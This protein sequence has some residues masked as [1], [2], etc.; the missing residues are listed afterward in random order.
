MHRE[1]P[2]T[3]ELDDIRLIVDGKKTMFRRIMDKQPD[4]HWLRPC[5]DKDTGEVSAYCDGPTG[6]ICPYGTVGSRLWVREEWRPLVEMAGTGY[7]GRT[8]VDIAEFKA[9]EG[10][11]I[12]TKVI[13]PMG[14]SIGSWSRYTW[15]PAAGGNGPWMDADE[16]PREVS[17][18]DLEITKIIVEPISE[19]SL[20]DAVAEGYPGSYTPAFCVG[21]EISDPDGKMPYDEFKDVW[22]QRFGLEKWN[23]DPWVWGVQFKVIDK[24]WSGSC[25]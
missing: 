4:Y 3:M 14:Q 22:C 19:I 6:V 9:H 7:M 2:I 8:A 25:E 15:S 16:M 11:L 24:R 1:Q 12:N 17:R 18:L 10:E 20:E 21:G 13:R 5:V 23:A